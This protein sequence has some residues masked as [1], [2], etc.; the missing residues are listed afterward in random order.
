MEFGSPKDA[1]E[2]TFLGALMG[3]QAA[4]PPRNSVRAC[5]LRPSGGLGIADGGL[6]APDPREK[7]LRDGRQ[8][9]IPERQVIE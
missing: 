4:P 2:S 7:D 3:P 6:V 5:P 8:T 1:G 9:R